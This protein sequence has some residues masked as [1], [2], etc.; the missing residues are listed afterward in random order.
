MA[1]ENKIIL[2]ADVK[3]LK[4]QL[5]EATLELQAA[6]EKFGE[7]SDEAVLAAQNVANIRD[8]IQGANEAAQLFDPGARFQALTNAASTAAGGIAAAQGALAL[9][10]GESEDVEKALLKVQSAMA[11]SQGLS[12]LKDIGKVGDELILSFKGLTAGANGFKKALISTGIGA[13]V[14]AVGLLVAYWEDIVALVGGV[15]KEQ[16]DLNMATQKD[17]EANQEKLEAIDGQTNQ[18]K[19]QGKSE[20]EILQLKMDQ[21]A[22]A[23][24]AAKVNLANA[25]ATKTAQVEAAQRN[26]AILAGILKFMSFPLTAILGSIDLI[27]AGL[28]ELGV[29]EESTNL[30]DDSTKYL[31][32]FVFDPEA[33]GAEG[34]KTI[35]EAEA[36]L[37]SLEEQQAGYQLSVLDSQKAAGEK[38]SAE[39]EKQ[40]K[41]EEAALAVLQEAKNKM[42]EK[43]EQEELAIN[44][45][46]KAKQKVLDEASIKDDGSLEK[47]RQS[48]IQAVQDKYA[49]EEAERKKAAQMQLNEIITQTRLDGIKDE[50]VK[51]REQ[52]LLEFQAERDAVLNNEKLKSEEKTALLLALKTQED[53]ALKTLQKTIDEADAIKELEKLD[54]QMLKDENDFNTQRTLL[55]Q[56]LDLLEQYH[57][58]GRISDDEYT[59]GVLANSNARKEIDKLENQAKVQNAEVASQLLGTVSDLVGK[60]TAAGKATA[61]ASTTIDTYLGAQKAYASQLIV[62]DPSSPIRAAIAAAI[63]IAGGIKNVRAIARTPVPG[64]GGGASVPS[65]S[66]AAPA[67]APAVPTLGN[68]PVTALGTMMQNQP[69][70]KAYVVESEVTNSQKRVADIERRAGF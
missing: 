70:L 54:A 69:P 12:Q 46:Y 48:E 61:I 16:K 21:T 5:R 49:K 13:L 33:V 45:A 34:D 15:S 47:A 2:D 38:A 52:I 9:F 30:L 63:A 8:E 50:N 53:Q 6:R 7:L 55:D 31:A 57:K 28:K 11:L 18:L 43:Q 25:N 51:A 20:E 37:N 64:G 41:A 1:E 60:N 3:P 36:V 19:L 27:S 10:G 29:L 23:I 22:E 24:L 26:Q 44:E 17:L 59:A 67:V 42:L 39:R 35:K 65:V 32:S 4:K 68:S 56:K 62:G 66:A 14:V 58:A 40:A